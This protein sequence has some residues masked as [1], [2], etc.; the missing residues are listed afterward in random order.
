MKKKDVSEKKGGKGETRQGGWK[1][2]IGR[3]GKE[4][5]SRKVFRDW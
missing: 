4:K 1:R 2:Q 3:Q 5:R